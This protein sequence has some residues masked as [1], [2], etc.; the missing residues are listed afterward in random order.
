MRISDETLHD[1]TVISADGKAIGSI[2]ELFISTS[3]WRIESVRIELH[4]DIAD[5]IG[6]SRT[7][8]HRGTIEL[9]VSFIQSVSDTVVLSVDVDQLREVH[10]TPA[11]DV[12][13]Q[14]ST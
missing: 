9:P 10:R 4:K 12:A 3:D 13:P 2:S 11:T 7:I 1:R 8:F 14:H 5:R 6:S